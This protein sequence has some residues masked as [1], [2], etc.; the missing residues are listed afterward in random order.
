MLSTGC[1]EGCCFQPQ[2]DLQAGGM[3]E[4]DGQGQPGSGAGSTNPAPVLSGV[5]YAL[6]GEKENAVSRSQVTI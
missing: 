2:C 3:L 4:S 1:D 5:W 6:A